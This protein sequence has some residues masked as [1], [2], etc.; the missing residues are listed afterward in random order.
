MYFVGKQ[1]SQPICFSISFN[2]RTLLRNLEIYYIERSHTLYFP[3]C[4]QPNYTRD[5][6]WIQL[7]REAAT[8]S[9]PAGTAALVN[10]TSRISSHTMAYS[11]LQISV[12]KW[13]YTH[14][15]IELAQIDTK[16]AQIPFPVCF[17]CVLFVFHFCFFCIVSI[18]RVSVHSVQCA[19][20]SMIRT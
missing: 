17:R 8:V 14:T 11:I 9:L 18:M 13:Q 12:K 2:I 1:L 3:P 7:A 19:C 6:Y 5:E 10:W 15:Q 4:S 20:S 16:T